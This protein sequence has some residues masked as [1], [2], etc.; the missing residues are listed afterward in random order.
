MIPMGI[1]ADI[2]G[3]IGDGRVC[4]PFENPPRQNLVADANDDRGVESVR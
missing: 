2:S 3:E 1:S 4:L